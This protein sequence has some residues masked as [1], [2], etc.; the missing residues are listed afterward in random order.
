M[1]II[2]EQETY[3]KIL[4]FDPF[5][6]DEA[7]DDLIT[8]FKASPL[9]KNL[10][11]KPTFTHKVVGQPDGDWFSRITF[12]FE[13]MTVGY[14]Y[15]RLRIDML[16]IRQ[17]FDDIITPESEKLFVVRLYDGFDNEWMDVSK[18]VSKTEAKRIWNEK[19][20]NGTEKTC[21]DDIDY[22]KIDRV[23]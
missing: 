13:Y 23:N 3:G 18:K 4:L 5:F 21:Y 6:L 9:Y 7:Y 20:K 19:T 8:K 11:F 16:R 12:I 10:Q 15:P 17:W 2:Q 22:F 1:K 14:K